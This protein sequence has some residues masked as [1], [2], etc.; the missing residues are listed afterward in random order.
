MIWHL[1]IFRSRIFAQWLYPLYVQH[2]IVHWNKGQGVAYLVVGRHTEATEVMQCPT[3]QLKVYSC[4][5]LAYS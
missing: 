3:H 4:Q 5:L 1:Q 2:V